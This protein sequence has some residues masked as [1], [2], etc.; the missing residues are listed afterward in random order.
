MIYHV[1]QPDGT[2]LYKLA[3]KWSF[4]ILVV[5]S[6]PV[7]PWTKNMHKRCLKSNFTTVTFY[8]ILAEESIDASMIHEGIAQFNSKFPTNSPALHLNVSVYLMCGNYETKRT[9]FYLRSTRKFHL[10]LLKSKNTFSLNTSANSRFHKPLK[11][12]N[13]KI[14]KSRRTEKLYVSDVLTDWSSFAA[15]HLNS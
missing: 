10:L 9:A 15:I 13:A 4:R 7:T 12:A 3:C 6:D 1:T 14:L 8:H 11:R 2:L 5:N